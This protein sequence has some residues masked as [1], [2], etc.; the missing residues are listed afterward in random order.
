MDEADTRAPGILHMLEFGLVAN[1]TNL[2]LLLQ[3]WRSVCSL[4]A[5]DCSGT[6]RPTSM[7]AAMPPWPSNAPRTRSSAAPSTQAHPQAP[8]TSPGSPGS[9]SSGLG[10]QRT[11]ARAAAGPRRGAACIRRGLWGLGVGLR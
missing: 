2:L 3:Y 4:E 1:H 8:E 10:L 5:S 6:D 9:A 11:G 7:E